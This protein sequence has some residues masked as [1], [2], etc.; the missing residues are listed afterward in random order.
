MSWLK[1]LKG[2]VKVNEPLSKYT[3]FKI[4]GPAKFLV[5]PLNLEDLKALLDLRKR[6]KFRFFIIGAGSNLL[7][8]DKGLKAVVMHL[9]A[10]FFRKVRQE[11]DILE[12]GSGI[13]LN[14]LMRISQKKG[15][16]GLEF[17]SGIPGTLGG[18]LAMNAA[19]WGKSIADF[20]EKVKVM[21]YNGSV[22]YL[23]R[24]Q[25]RFGYRSS[26]L[27]RYIIFAAR[28]K[29]TKAPLEKIARVKQRCLR[30]RSLTQDNS[31]PNAGCIFKN[32]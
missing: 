28:L 10:H 14:T 16:S 4:G 8:A 12:A 20:V 32:P 25:I 31:W 13:M 18:A 9:G 21:D 22:K 29:F 23:D 1:G 24:D 3:T 15:L 17:L 2:K 6:Y 26:S 7:V 19:C 5:E 11:G 30:R 27:Q